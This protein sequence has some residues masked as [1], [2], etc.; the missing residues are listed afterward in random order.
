LKIKY[1]KKVEKS[2]KVEKKVLI[3]YS[4]IKH[5]TE[6]QIKLIESIQVELETGGNLVVFSKEVPK[7]FPEMKEEFRLMCK[8]YDKFEKK[9]DKLYFEI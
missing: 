9:F 3:L 6:K 8:L 5:M 4:K 2:W 7:L 1:I